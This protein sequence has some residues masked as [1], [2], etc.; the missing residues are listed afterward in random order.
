MANARRRFEVVL[1]DHGEG[2]CLASLPLLVEEIAAEQGAGDARADG[3]DRHA[4][5][6]PRRAAYLR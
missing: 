1:A 4:V 5:A 6:R 2:V 3:G